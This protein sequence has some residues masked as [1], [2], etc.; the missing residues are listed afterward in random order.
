MIILINHL[1]NLARLW[2]AYNKN[3]RSILQ[4]STHKCWTTPM[5]VSTKDMGM[6]IGKD[7]GQFLIESALHSLNS[8]IEQYF[9][10]DWYY[11]LH[12]I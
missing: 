6:V 9:T 4:A 2:H 8:L 12:D 10:T 1:K 7:N 5:R 11:P 3:C